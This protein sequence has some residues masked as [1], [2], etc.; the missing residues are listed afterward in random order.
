MNRIDLLAPSL[1]GPP[2]ANLGPGPPSCTTPDT[3]KGIKR[4]FAR[5]CIC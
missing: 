1:V 4:V 3:I 5:P 2:R